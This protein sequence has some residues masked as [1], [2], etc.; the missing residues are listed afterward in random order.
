MALWLTVL[1]CILRPVISL[2]WTNIRMC[3]DLDSCVPSM[4]TYRQS[5][6]FNLLFIC[7][8]ISH[9]ERQ[10]DVDKWVNFLDDLIN[11]LWQISDYLVLK[12]IRFDHFKY[13]FIPL[14]TPDNEIKMLMIECKGNVNDIACCQNGGKWSVSHLIDY[15]ARSAQER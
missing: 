11:A 13:F 8:G 5:H 10:V 15:W 3:P 12:I 14:S 7:F 6:T 1:C 4:I 9:Y 2:K